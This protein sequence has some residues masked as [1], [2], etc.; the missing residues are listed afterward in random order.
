[1]A[2]LTRK[3]FFVILKH[4]ENPE[5]V[6]RSVGAWYADTHYHHVLLCFS[7]NPTALRK[8]M[9]EREMIDFPLTLEKPRRLIMAMVRYNTRQREKIVAG[10]R[11]FAEKKGKY[12]RWLEEWKEMTTPEERGEKRCQPVI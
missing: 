1:M 6:E 9:Q 12:M 7:N 4:T 8:E 11:R 10:Q 5:L 2:D 3:D